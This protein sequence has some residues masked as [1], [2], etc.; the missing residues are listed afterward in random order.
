M[1]RNNY[2]PILLHQLALW[3]E[4]YCISFKKT[5][6]SEYSE[7][8]ASEAASIFNNVFNQKK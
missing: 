3:N 4:V 2:D 5:L 6:D 7:K 1:E 8:K